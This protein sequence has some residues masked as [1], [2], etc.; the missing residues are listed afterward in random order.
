ML[1]TFA[2]GFVT[3]RFSGTFSKTT[4]TSIGQ[5]T[6]D[7]LRATPQSTDAMSAESSR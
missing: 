4:G 6:V 1:T 3:T 7:W 2:E 5:V